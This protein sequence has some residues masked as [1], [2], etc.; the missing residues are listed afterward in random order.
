MRR[1]VKEHMCSSIWAA[2][3]FIRTAGLRKTTESSG[4]ISVCLCLLIYGAL[5][6]LI[7]GPISFRPPLG[8]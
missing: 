3:S 1:F 8:K 4:L 5:Q 2:V 6:F 7:L